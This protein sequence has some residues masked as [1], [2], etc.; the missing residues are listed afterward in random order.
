MFGYGVKDNKLSESVVNIAYRYAQLRLCKA[1]DLCITRPLDYAV[2][3]STV[4]DRIAEA[5]DCDR[6]LVEEAFNKATDKVNH[7]FTYPDEDINK[8]FDSF[9]EN[10]LEVAL[11]EDPKDRHPDHPQLEEL[12]I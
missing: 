4:H 2:E 11:R 1:Q 6:E 12:P 3:R 7:L 8:V 10:L 5:L 9:C